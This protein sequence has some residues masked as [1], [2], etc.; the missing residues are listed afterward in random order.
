ME[1]NDKRMHKYTIR[2]E[3]TISCVEKFGIR[4]PNPPHMYGTVPGTVQDILL[5]PVFMIYGVLVN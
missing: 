4:S 3:V 2:V 5:P 1:F